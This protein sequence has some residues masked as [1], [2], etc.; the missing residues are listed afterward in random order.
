MEEE[1]LEVELEVELVFLELDLLELEVK[2][3]FL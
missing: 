1:L 3:V 2:L